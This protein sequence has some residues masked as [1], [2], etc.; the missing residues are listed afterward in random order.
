MP[1]EDVASGNEAGQS[2]DITPEEKSSAIDLEALAKIIYELLKQEA[3]I[4]AE[5]LGRPR[6]GRGD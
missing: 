3:R 1:A 2:L 5:R 6:N 4:E